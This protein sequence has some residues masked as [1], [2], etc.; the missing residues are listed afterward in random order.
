MVTVPVFVQSDRYILAR[1]GAGVDILLK[2]LSR[3]P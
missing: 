1:T 2:V 3:L